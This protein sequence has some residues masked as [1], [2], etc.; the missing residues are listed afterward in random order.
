MSGAVALVC[1]Q[2]EAR[3]ICAQGKKI[4]LVASFIILKTVVFSPFAF[5]QKSDSIE[6]PELITPTHLRFYQ[7]FWNNP[8]I[9]SLL[10]IHFFYKS[11]F[12]M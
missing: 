1:V 12:R 9:S 2:A 10:C 7:M 4:T 5:R 3:L 6:A 8:M 11:V